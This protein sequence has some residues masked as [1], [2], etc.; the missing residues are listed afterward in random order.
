MGLIFRLVLAVLALYLLSQLFKRL[1]GQSVG[2]KYLPAPVPERAVTVD[3]G[4]ETSARHIRGRGR[5]IAAAAVTLLCALLPWGDGATFKVQLVFAPLV[6]LPWA[7]PVARAW[8]G[9][10][11][12]RWLALGCCAIALLW[13]LFMLM[14]GVGD[15]TKGRDPTLLVSGLLMLACALAYQYS[16]MLYTRDQGR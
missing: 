1:F 15:L 8:H 16:L 13:A 12:R 11:M 3:A 10:P 5:I 2:P 6:M 9:R 14:L 7:Y 4:V